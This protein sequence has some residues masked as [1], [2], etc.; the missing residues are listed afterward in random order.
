[1]EVHKNTEL[2]TLKTILW[3]YIIL[4]IIIA[5][6]N[7]GYADRADSQVAE[8]I[9]WFWHFYENWIKTIFIIVCS[10]LTIRIFGIK[11]KSTMRSKNL[12][13]L[14]LAALI[15]HII[16]PLVLENNEIYFFAMPLPWT[17]V[18]LQLL[19]PGTSFYTSHAPLWGVSGVIAALIVYGC[20]SVVVF[21]GTLLFGRRWQCSTLCMFNGFAAEVFAPAFP[22]VGK[23]KQLKPTILSIFKTMRWLFLGIA[24]F[25]ALW[26]I[27]FLSG[28]Q[29]FGTPGMIGTLEIIKYL[30]AELL[31]A[32]FLWVVLTGRGYCYYCP[33][34]TVLAFLGRAFGQKIETDRS[35]CIGCNRCNTIC[36]MTIDIKEKAQKGEPVK[37]IRCVGCGHCVDNCPTKTL[38]YSTYF[39]NWVHRRKTEAGPFDQ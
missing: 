34:G 15:I 35:N 16:L 3:V 20:I 5:G 7:Y 10:I 8:K 23:K 14:I 2:K 22:L 13:G 38:A 12:I 29:V 24:V 17:S 9:N 27:L 31:L 1:M 30:S 25:F 18:P 36:P 33:L 11:G 21:A 19:D 4:C 32:I 6:L 39:L 28:I 37:D 26:W